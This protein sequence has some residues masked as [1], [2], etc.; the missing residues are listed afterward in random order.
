MEKYEKNM[1][2]HW[3][4]TIGIKNSPNSVFI[5]GEELAFLEF[6]QHSWILSLRKLLK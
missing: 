6:S 5:S 2:I 4:D 3:I 1:E